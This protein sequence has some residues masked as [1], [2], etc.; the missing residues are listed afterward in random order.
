MNKLIRSI[1]DDL[2]RCIAA[3]AEQNKRSFS[4]E[5]I[6]ALEHYAQEQKRTDKQFWDGTNQYGKTIHGRENK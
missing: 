5:V 3:L 1:P 4:K 6:V 2:A